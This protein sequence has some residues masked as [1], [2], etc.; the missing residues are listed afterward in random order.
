MV[1]NFYAI[2]HMLL[3]DATVLQKLSPFFTVIFCFLILKERTRPVQWLCIATAFLGSLLVV[4][5]TGA[6]LANPA[7]LAA[8]AA[9]LFAGFAYAMVRC[10]N[11]RGEKGPVIVLCFSAFS[12]LVA[13]PTI[14]FDYTPMTFSQ[15]ACLILVGLFAAGGQF[16]LTYAYR[17]APAA[18]ISVFDYTA[19]IVAAILGFIFFGQL[20]DGLSYLGYAVIVGA[21]V[22]MFFYNR[23]WQKKELEKE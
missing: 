12:C 23:Y 6:G 9:S 15:F 14:L 21:G 22:C 2:D 20:A 7:A 13:L 10:L 4:K 3:S 17:Y 16:C 19:P 18:E 8:L 1:G 11:V 5:P